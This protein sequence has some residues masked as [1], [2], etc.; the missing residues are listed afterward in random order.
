MTPAERITKLEAKNTQQREQIA[1]LLERARD[2]EA[3]LVKDSRNSGKPPS[4]DGLKR[5]LP[6]TRSLQ[7]KWAKKPG[8][9]VGHTGE[10][11]HLVAEPDTV[12]VHR[13]TVCATCHASLESGTERRGGCASAA[14]TWT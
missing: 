5:R 11:L 9:L 10:M 2:L 1:V 8:G 7:R 4:T 6:R 13:L 3:R 14:R 12:V